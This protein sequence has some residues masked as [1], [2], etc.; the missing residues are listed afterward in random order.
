M[1]DSDPR[2]IWPLPA[3]VYLLFLAW[4]QIGADVTMAMRG[5]PR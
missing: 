1:T 3:L 2:R 4:T 5:A